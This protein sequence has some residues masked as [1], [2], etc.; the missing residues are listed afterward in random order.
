[1]A[2][3]LEIRRTSCTS[4][5]L[6]ADGRS[7]L[8]ALAKATGL[9]VSAVQ[10]RGAPARAGRGDRATSRTR[11]R[12]IGLP[13]ARSSRSFRWIPAGIRDPGHAAGLSEIESMPF[14]RRGRQLR[15]LRPGGHADRPGDADQGNRARWPTWHPTTVCCRR[16]SSGRPALQSSPLTGIC[17]RGS[18]FDGNY[19]VHVPLMTLTVTAPK[20]PRPH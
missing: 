5:L 13:L 18:Y 15:A 10:A 9:S 20:R 12:A 19:T 1:M 14:R 6:I 4:L 11:P 8:K 17:T 7:T 2:R 16:L 3:Q